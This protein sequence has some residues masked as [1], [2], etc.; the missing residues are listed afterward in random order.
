MKLVTG[1][2]YQGKQQWV[3]T[4]YHLKQSQAADGAVCSYEEIKT[5]KVLN[6]FHLLVQRWMQE[7][8][9]PSEETALILEENPELIIITD[10][11]GCG[12]VP[13]DPKERNG[14]KSMEDSAAGWQNRRIV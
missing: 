1:G 8:R 9:E 3:L 2:C 10:E 11:I 6:H 5:A 12:I 4:H 13:M 7:N 14:V